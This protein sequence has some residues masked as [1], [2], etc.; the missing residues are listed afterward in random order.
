[1][2]KSRQTSLG[3]KVSYGLG[4]GII[5]VK[6]MIFHFFFLFFF[7]NVMGLPA[8]LII[9]ITLVSLLIDAITDPVMGQISD[10]YS[11]PKWGRRHKFM[12]MAILPTAIC[13]ALLFAPPDTL[14][15]TG[16]FIWVFTLIIAVRIGLT[17]YGVPYYAM[18]AELSRNYNERT[19]IISVREF[20]N[21][22]FNIAVFIIGFTIFLPE[23]EQ[24]EDGMMNKAGYAPFVL[25]MAIIGAISA[26]IAVYGTRH[27]IPDMPKSPPKDQQTGWKHTFL[28]IKR[29]VQIRDVVWVSGGYGLIVILYGVGSALSF[30]I[31][32]YLWQFSQEYKLIVSFMPFIFVVPAV[33]LAA[34]IAQKID[35]RPAVLIFCNLYF[36]CSILPYLAYM[37]GHMPNTGSATLMWVI[38]LANGTGFFG[39]VGVIVI[40]NSM[41]ADVADEM[42]L[43][44]GKRQEGILYAAFSFANKMTFGAGLIITAL[45]LILLRFPRQKNPSEI[46]QTT[47]DGLAVSAIWVA[48]IFGLS[49]LYCFNRYTLTRTRHRAI[50]AELGLE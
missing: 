9:F 42:Q 22:L 10:N 5:S 39:L 28:E 21:N 6:N 29:A 34:I 44:T 25:T 12:L 23:S 43:T 16:L 11:T 48:L 20:F 38:A 26:F 46:N 15:T 13:L 4:H 17:V 18:A 31:G 1:M 37:T 2:G 47:I 19:H 14:S 24:F 45:T 49:S 33:F 8:G 7:S 32:V 40:A 3:T 27:K 41:L 50:Q 30:Y 36:A 35:K